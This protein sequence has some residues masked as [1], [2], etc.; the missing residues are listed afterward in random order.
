MATKHIIRGKQYRSEAEI[1]DAMFA[2][3]AEF[4]GNMTPDARAHWNS[5]GSARE[6]L[7]A[8]EGRLRTAARGAGSTESIELGQPN[9]R[10]EQSQM[11]QSRGE[12]ARDLG[13]RGIER[14]N[15]GPTALKT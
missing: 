12:Q 9:F 10:R 1:T 3:V 7:R 6:E 15:A 8:N 5:L 13:L 14:L 2:I 11:F 4:G